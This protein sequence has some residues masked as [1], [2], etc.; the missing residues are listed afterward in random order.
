MPTPAPANPNPTPATPGEPVVAPSFEQRLH[1]FWEN[2]KNQNAIFAV[3][4]IVLLVIIGRNGYDFYVDRHERSIGAEYATASTSEKLKSFAA[5]HPGHQL[6][7]AAK[8]RLGDE[9]YLGGNFTQAALE[10]QAAADVLKTGPFAGRARLGAAMAKLQGG[11][12]AEGENQLKQLAADASQMKSVRA[13]AAYQL[14]SEASAAG[15]NDEAL[16]YLDQVMAVEQSGTWAQ[17]AM[18]LRTTLPAP[19]TPISLPP[20]AA[21]TIKVPAKP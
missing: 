14:A 10:Y 9:A 5:A 12:T 8:L 16:K 4:A 3:C 21:P 20:S 11:Q 1:E 17:R 6:A 7:G 2:K 19:T 15:R 18:I 13:E